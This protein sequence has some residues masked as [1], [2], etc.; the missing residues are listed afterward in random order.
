MSS[1]SYINDIVVSSRIRLAR[2][3]V[4]IPFPM[5]STAEQAEQALDAL[6]NATGAGTELAFE[7]FEVIK[8]DDLNDSA[9][10]SMVE[11]HIISP[12]LGH[13]KS[14]ATILNKDKTVS[15]MV[16]EED[17]VRIQC[18]LPGFS[19]YD[20]Y[21]K[22]NAIDDALQ[23]KISY[24]FDEKLGFLTSCPSNLGTGMRAGVMVHIPALVLNSRLSN[25]ANM[26]NKFGLAL[27]GIYGEGSDALGDLFQVSNQYSLGL[28]EI[29]I[30][31]HIHSITKEIIKYERDERN[32]LLI[33]QE[34]L[35]RDKIQRA[36]GILTN[37]YML[38]TKEAMS[39]LSLLRMGADLEIFNGVD[40]S[41]LDS[42]IVNIQP[43]TLSLTF[44]GKVDERSRDIFRAEYIQKQLTQN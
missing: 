5:K 28:T 12:E 34:D 44:N 37:A 41:I 32:K 40:Y 38:T 33:N 22:A 30:V 39:L 31:N 13:N 29:E 21:A 26:A 9:R 1:R 20:S 4:D 42:I 2:N 23:D 24:C 19:L 25:I 18:I 15:I 27:R 3:L 6:E 43:A 8:V 36:Y 17:H 10:M 11:R 16:N 35:I 7:E 14:A